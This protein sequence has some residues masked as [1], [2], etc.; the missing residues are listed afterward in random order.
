MLPHQPTL[1][2]TTRDLA[3]TISQPKLCDLLKESHF[4]RQRNIL[5]MATLPLLGLSL[6]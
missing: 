1:L 4:M 3:P 5:V 2:V 6:P